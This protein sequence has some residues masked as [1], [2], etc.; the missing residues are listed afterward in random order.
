MSSARDLACPRLGWIH[1]AVIAVLALLAAWAYLRFT[2]DDA[3][4]FQ[5]DVLQFK[6][7]ST[8]GEKNFG[9]PL[10]IWDALPILF[11]DKLPPGKQDMGWAAFGFIIDEADYAA[12]AKE[13]PRHRRPVGTSVRNH[14]GMDRIF[15]NCAGCHV[16]AVRADEKGKK[17][18]VAGMPSNTVDLEAFQNFLTA[19]AADKR[20]NADDILNIVDENGIEL[21]FINRILLRLLVVDMMRD[22]VGGISRRFAFTEHE[23]A[24]GPGRFDTFSPAK[25]LMNWPHDLI[26]PNEQIGAVDFP[27]VW[28]QKPKRGMWLHWDGNNNSV[29]ERNR[30]AAFGTGATFPTLDR[31]SVKRFAGYL[32][33]A[34]PPAFESI[35]GAGSIDKAK[36]EQGKSVYMSYCAR[37]HGPSGRD[38][39]GRFVGQVTDIQYIGT[40]RHRLDNY[41]R[42]LLIN[43]GALYASNPS[44]RFQYFRK[45]NGYAN[46]PLDGVWLRA[47]YLHNGSVPT[48][49][50]L[51]QP[52]DKRPVAF[53]RGYDVYDPTKLGFVSAPSEL[54]DDLKKSLFCYAVN[55]AGEAA[56]G[57]FKPDNRKAC[58]AA[59]CKGNG[60]AGHEYG[61]KLPDADKYALIEYLKSF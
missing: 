20:F 31:K 17:H 29:E 49:W 2:R 41:T 40:D 56:C 57:A 45:T 35:F 1:W 47:P 54:S 59:T 60:N 36:A 7:G 11:K 43:Q 39:T 46:A 9:I 22:L 4:M 5:D 42:D 15:L 44:E 26:P 61:T 18:Y 19:A 21:D 48:M 3:Q 50:D 27:S 14:M 37:C 34:E 6:Y 25:A 53:F 12:D 58:N 55:A 8:G 51:L 28:M 32:D 23:P 33:A 30:S 10:A 38:F 13:K 24:F 16:G 52:A